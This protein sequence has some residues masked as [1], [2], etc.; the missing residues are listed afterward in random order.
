MALAKANQQTNNLIKESSKATMMAASSK[1]P[2]V[3]K[4]DYNF[5]KASTEIKSA[6]G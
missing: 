6:I 2:N 5:K 4:V 1:T 3:Q